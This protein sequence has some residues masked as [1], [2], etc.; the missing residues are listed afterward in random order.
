MFAFVLYSDLLAK[1]CHNIRETLK[2]VSEQSLILFYCSLFLA[3]ML[4]CFSDP[5]TGHWH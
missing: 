2:E 5:T 4:Q 1:A 3:V